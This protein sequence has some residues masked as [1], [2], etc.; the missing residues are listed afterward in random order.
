MK[1][2]FFNFFILFSLYLILITPLIASAQPEIDKCF[3]Y[4][5]AQDYTRAIEAG[6]RAVQL[7]PINPGAYFCLGDAYRRV[8]ELNLAL[9]NM[10]EAERFATNKTELIFIYNRLGLIY[11]GMGDL[12]NALFYHSKSL[13]LARE[14]GDRHIEAGELNNIA[15]IF[16]TRGELDKALSYYEESLRLRTDEK[17]KAVTYNNIG[18]IYAS[19]EDFVKAIDYLKKAVE[20]DERYGNYHSL[21]QSLLNLGYIYSKA[22]DFLNAEKYLLDGLNRIQRLND[23]LWEA[24]AYKYLGWLYID[25]GDKKTAREYLTKA[26]NLFQSIGAQG[27]AVDTLLVLSLTVPEQKRAA[28][29]GGIEV[30]SKGVKA[31]ALE[32]TLDDEGLYVVRELFR[33]SINTT[34]ISGVKETGAFSSEGIE[35]TAQAVKTFIEK[36]KQSGV[37]DK[38]IFVVASSA[39]GSVKNRE[40]LSSRI[41]ELTGYRIVFLTV[42]DEITYGIVGTVPPDYYYNSILV[43][44]GSG[45]TKI[46][47]LEKIGDTLNV[48]NFEIPYGT[49]SLTEE[50]KKKGNLHKELSR[51]LNTKVIPILKKESEKNPAYLNRKNVFLI[52]GAVWALTTLQK[53]ERINEGYVKFTS[54]DIEDFLTNLRKNPEKLLNPD[55]SKLKEEEKQQAQ[56]QIEKLKDVFT[57][58]NLISGASLLNTISKELKFTNRQIFFPRH[59]NW[60][61]GY[62]VLNGYWT[63]KEGAK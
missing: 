22:G 30:G 33:E 63:E 41:Q 19:K 55:I 37:P 28:L 26:Y 27:E 57:I 50:G 40:A 51:I 18:M 35:E 24:I 36:A 42:K 7:Y 25:K 44:I 3:N 45:N 46:G 5:A 43:D 56:K 15:S 52:G 20:I 29:Y 39:V 4:L 48:K 13:N 31:I 10:K 14:L 21:A 32:L 9:S 47:Y 62:V 2:A 17:D 58:D 54:K 6:K 60:L 1:R 23:K 49:V 34:I 12:D 11:K 59:G 16:N 61:I 53:P 8:G 38:N